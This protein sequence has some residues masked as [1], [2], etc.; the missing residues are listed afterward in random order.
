MGFA[1]ELDLDADS[2]AP[3]IALSEAIY[4]TCGGK[5]LTDRG[6]WPHLSLAVFTEL[7]PP[8]LQELLA[9][10]A[11]TTAPLT[12]TLVA[13]G[14]FPASQGTVYL[15]PVVTV[16]LLALHARFYTLLSA[17][18][19]TSHAYYAPGNWMPHCTVGIDV[20]AAQ[21]GQAVAL[22]RQAALFGPVTLTSLRLIEFHPARPLYTH[23]LQGV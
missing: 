12:V 9:D 3:V 6:G 2:A 19:V 16:A 17:V 10:F 21:I 5:N 1:V 23:N 20:P 4:A 22:C 18:G 7:Q 14:T 11:A 8:L 13:V 15:A